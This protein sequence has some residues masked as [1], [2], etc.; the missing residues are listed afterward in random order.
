MSTIIAYTVEDE[1][2][3]SDNRRI[4]PPSPAPQNCALFYARFA[5]AICLLL[6]RLSAVGQ[7]F[8]ISGHLNANSFT[9]YYLTFDY[10]R[11]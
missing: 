2:D 3:D 4:Y 1:N 5:F 11:T 8:W 9:V 7:S 6:P 10:N